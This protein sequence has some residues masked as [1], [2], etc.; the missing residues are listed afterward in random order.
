MPN[1]REIRAWYNRH[2]A[3]Q[4]LSGMRPREAYPGFLDLLDAAPA[5][6]P[7]P[8]P[9]R[10]LLDVSCGTGFLLRAATGRG[11]GAVG[12]DLSDQATRIA[13]EAA[14]R[15][16]VAVSSAEALCL[17]SGVF[18]YVTCLGSLEHFLDMRQGLREMRRVAR[19]GA[20][21]CIMVPNR[22]FLAWKLGAGTGTAQ[23]D[24]NEN[25]Q[26]LAEW[27]ALFDESGFREVR[28]LADWWHAERL[29]RRSG[30]A[31]A[32]LKGLLL[33]TLWRWLPLRLEYQ[34]IFI[35]ESAADPGA[36]SAS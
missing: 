27:R 29:R 26:T 2:Y 36:L 6:A 13:R 4:G 3:S 35:L 28:V 34:F 30:S 19:P 5:P 15:S 16:A 1:A 10:R 11:L 21:F 32:R 25:L 31:A 14:P 17:R 23:Q 20:R 7:A 18:D 22:D 9:G 12:V 24:I 33:G 8:A